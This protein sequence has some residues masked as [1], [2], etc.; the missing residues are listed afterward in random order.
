MPV[1]PLPVIEMKLVH[2]VHRAALPVLRDRAR[3]TLDL[4]HA[5]QVGAS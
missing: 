5:A 3:V 1:E 2:N 4:L